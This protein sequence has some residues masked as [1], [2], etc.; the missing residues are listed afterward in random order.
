MEEK[1]HYPYTDK[2]QIGVVDLTR[3]DLATPEDQGYNIDKWAR[4]FKA[5]T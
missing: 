1:K 2:L 5:K 3:I 4:L